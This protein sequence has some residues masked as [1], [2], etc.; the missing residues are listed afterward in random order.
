MKSTHSTAPPGITLCARNRITLCAREIASLECAWKAKGD[1]PITLAC[2]RP[3]GH[4]ILRP[5]GLVRSMLMHF[6]PRLSAEK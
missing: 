4:A 2:P 3:E 6:F 5:R 1:A